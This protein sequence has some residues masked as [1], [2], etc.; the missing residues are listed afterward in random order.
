MMLYDYYGHGKATAMHRMFWVLC[1]CQSDTGPTIVQ[2]IPSHVQS[3]NTSSNGYKLIPKV[4]PH[5][6]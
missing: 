1:W 6:P 4:T 2:H 3:C 5:A